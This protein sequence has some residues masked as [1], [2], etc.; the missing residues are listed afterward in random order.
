LILLVIYLIATPQTGATFA[1][2]GRAVAAAS[3]R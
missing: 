2:V 1:A 3:D